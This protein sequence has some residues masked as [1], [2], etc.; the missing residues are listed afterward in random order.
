[1]KHPEDLRHPEDLSDLNPVT[2]LATA[3]GFIQE[4]GTQLASR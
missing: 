4:V 3:S 1:M 2:P